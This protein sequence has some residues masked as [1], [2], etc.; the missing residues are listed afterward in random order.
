MP[1]AATRSLCMYSSSAMPKGAELHNHLHSAVF[2]ETLIRDAV[3]DKLCVD[4]AAHAFA[5][6]Q[7]IGDEATGLRGGRRSRRGRL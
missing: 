2:A 3:E 7:A 1:F 5:K 6:P 4:Q